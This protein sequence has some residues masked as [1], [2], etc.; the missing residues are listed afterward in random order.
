MHLVL[1]VGARPPA[2]GLPHQGAAV[3]HGEVPVPGQVAVQLP[4]GLTSGAGAHWLPVRPTP[5]LV[6]A[7]VEI[8]HT[9]DNDVDINTVENCR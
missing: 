7:V 9:V 2:P 4:A 5:H 6:Q 1:H 8:Q 3:Q